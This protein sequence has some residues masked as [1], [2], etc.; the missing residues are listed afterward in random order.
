MEEQMAPPSG[1]GLIPTLSLHIPKAPRERQYSA[2][3]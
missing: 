3:P 2:V 1:G